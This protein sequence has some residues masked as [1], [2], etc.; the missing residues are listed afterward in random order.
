MKARN[1]LLGAFAS[2]FATTAFSQS[3]IAGVNLR[4]PDRMFTSNTGSIVGS[5]ANGPNL[6]ASREIFAL[7]YDAAAT[8][9]WAIDFATSEYGT[10]DPAAGGFQSM[11]VSTLPLN[12]ANGLTAAPDGDT[13]YVVGQ[14]GGNTS[15]VWVGDIE[16]GVFH[17]LAQF[18]NAFIADIACDRQG[19]VYGLSLVNDSLYKIDPMTSAVTFVGTHG[20]A[21][22]FAQGLDFDWGSDTL[23]ASLYIG[24]GVGQFCSLDT[25]NGQILTSMSTNAINAQLKFAVEIPVDGAPIGSTYCVANANSAGFLGQIS[26]QGSLDPMDDRVTLT[27]SLLPTGQFGIFVGSMTSGFVPNGGGTSNGNICLGGVIGRFNR[28]G[29]ILAV[30]PSGSFSLALDLASIPQANGVVSVMPGQTWYFQAWHRDG[31]GLGSNFTRG[32]QLDFQ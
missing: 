18:T 24:S 7:D 6:P 2:F 16:T 26:A 20:L 29:E 17:P 27:A 19:I 31:V 15:Q 8:T 3:P 5:Y 13:W 25:M 21:T 30:S 12:F 4:G 11:G 1:L 22:D 9:L 28:A 23:Y 14:L 10:L 32:L